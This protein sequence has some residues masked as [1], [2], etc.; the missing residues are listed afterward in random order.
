MR[1]GALHAHG[2]AAADRHLP[3]SDCRKASGSHFIPFGVWPTS[4]FKYSGE[5]KVFAKR[6]FCP[7]CGSRIAWLR[8]GKMEI[9]LGSLDDAP[10]GIVPEYEL[11]TGRRADW[12]N[13]LPWAEQ[14]EHDSSDAATAED[15]PSG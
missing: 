3:L 10:T 13:P 14:F 9:M 2:C 5:T 12:M 8:D 4:E 11:W 15:Q 7:V 6:S 1:R